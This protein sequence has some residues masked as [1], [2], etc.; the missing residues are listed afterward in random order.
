MTPEL[1]PR[2]GNVPVAISYKTAP[3]QNK[4]VRASNSFARTGSGSAGLSTES[5]KRLRI[6]REF[7]R[8]ELQRDVTTQLQV[9]R[10]VNHTHAPAS[11]LA[12]DAV[13]GDCLP[14]GLRRSS[15][16]RECYGEAWL[17]S[18]SAC[19]RAHPGATPCHL[20]IR[21]MDTGSQ[22]YFPIRVGNQCWCDD[23]SR[24]GDS[25][26]ARKPF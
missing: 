9:F 24:S 8:Q 17:G 10:L 19:H 21:R 22:R 18:I 7:I 4:S 15:H 14:H 11:D 16:R 5:L 23:G 20:C 25:K 6:V 3:N 26:V 1:S 12:Q 13:M 2:K